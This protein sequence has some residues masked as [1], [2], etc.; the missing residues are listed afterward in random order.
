MVINIIYSLVDCLLI[1][2]GS[3]RGLSYVVGLSNLMFF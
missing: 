3:I 2:M 1:Q